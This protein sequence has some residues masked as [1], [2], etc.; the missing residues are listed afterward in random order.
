LA[1]QFEVIEKAIGPVIE[2]EESVSMWRMPATFA[3]DYKR[4]TEYLASQG[5][6]CVGMPYARYL[7]MNWEVELNR[8]KFATFITMLIRKWHFFV[9][10]PVSKVIPGK[11]ELK[12]QVIPGQRF[13]RGVHRG[14]YQKCGVTYKALFDWAIAHSLLLKNE[15]IECYVNDPHEVD[16][17]DIETVILIPLQQDN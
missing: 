7:D 14:P 5:A 16:K 9:G 1:D 17:A 11:A 8:G 6:E 15:A 4:I 12:S 3:R 10:M 13:V 2:I